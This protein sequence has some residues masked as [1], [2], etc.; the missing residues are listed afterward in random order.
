MKIIATTY[1]L[2]VTRGNETIFA[3]ARKE[4]TVSQI[5]TGFFHFFF[6]KHDVQL[7]VI[8]REKMQR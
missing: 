7:N 5:I 4:N 1:K 2:T 8:Q 3:S 6:S